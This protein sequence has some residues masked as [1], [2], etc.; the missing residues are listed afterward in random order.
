MMS[1][2]NFRNDP[3]RAAAAGRIGGR[4]SPGNF[5]NDPERARAAGRKGGSR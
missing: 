3:K 1:S 4:M 2:G 5:K